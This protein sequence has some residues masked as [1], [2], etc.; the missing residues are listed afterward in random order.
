MFG[1]GKWNGPGG[2]LQKDETL[3]DCV[4]REVYEETGLIVNDLV[5]HGALSHFFGQDKE[6]DWVVHIFSTSKF[7]GVIKA[8]EEGELKWF[9]FQDVPYD[10]MWEDDRYWLPSVLRG[11][12]VEGEFFFTL[13]GKKLIRHRF[14]SKDKPF[15]DLR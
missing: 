6:A 4:I 14:K 12:R 7:E 13:D 15:S 9:K 5:Y 8:N 3:Q 1:E 2:K 11:S 10:E